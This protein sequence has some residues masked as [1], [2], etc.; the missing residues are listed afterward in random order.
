MAGYPIN[1]GAVMSANISVIARQDDSSYP[2]PN[3]ITEYL[4]DARVESRDY[5]IKV[6][7]KKPFSW[8]SPIDAN[9]P[10]RKGRSSTT[11]GQSD[12]PAMVVAE[13][14]NVPSTSVEPS[15]S[16]AV[17]L[18]H[19]LQFLLQFLPQVPHQL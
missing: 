17:C 6:R 3:T 9:N 15:S 1:V 19:H 14:V 10:K 18:H 13:A 2:Y 5:D 8:Y 11:T 16:A 7:P 4:T 12:E